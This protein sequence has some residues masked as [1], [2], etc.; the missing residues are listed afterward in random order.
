[1]ADGI[2]GIEA[3]EPAVAVNHVV[4]E[5]RQE[6]VYVNSRK[7]NIAITI[8]WSSPVMTEGDNPQFVRYPTQV[9]TINDIGN[10]TD[11]G[12]EPSGISPRIFNDNDFLNPEMLKRYPNLGGLVKDL[13]LILESEE[14]RTESV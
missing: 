12:F 7:R 10:W 13:L 9:N 1:M 4:I 6:K 11:S 3:M 8:D 2:L 5:A 14:K